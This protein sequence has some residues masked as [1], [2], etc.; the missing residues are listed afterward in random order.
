MTGTVCPKG[1]GEKPSRALPV[2]ESGSTRRGDD[3]EE[4]GGVL[5][6]I[7]VDLP[8]LGV[9]DGLFGSLRERGLE[10]VRLEAQLVHGPSDGAE[11]VLRGQDEGHRVVLLG[12]QD[13]TP[14]RALLAEMA[15]R[16]RTTVIAVVPSG[17][18]HQLARCVADGAAGAIGAND[19]VQ[20]ALTIFDQAMNGVTCLPAVIVS[21][22]IQTAKLDAGSPELSEQ[23]V[24]LLRALAEG[25][26]VGDLAR[27]TH[28][29]RR[30]MTRV[31]RKLYDSIGVGNRRQAVQWATAR[32][33]LNAPRNTGVA[34]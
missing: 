15:Q 25:V 17:D 7:A 11:E 26:P 22:A 10:V 12:V 30:T 14:S 19:S 16:P 2:A 6:V 20:Q 27:S 18:P 28:R 4:D 32:G 3:P 23:Q 29:S 13:G 24:E 21:E 9:V 8:P 33:L 31:L 5:Q 34:S 1:S